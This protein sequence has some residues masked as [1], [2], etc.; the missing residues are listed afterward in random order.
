MKRLD[1]VDKKA[2][3]K[4]SQHIL[5]KIII[6]ITRWSATF[7]DRMDLAEYEVHYW[8]MMTSL[9]ATIKNGTKTQLYWR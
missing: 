8:R 2:T 5:G 6:L 7:I 9:M 1:H 3:D 4:A